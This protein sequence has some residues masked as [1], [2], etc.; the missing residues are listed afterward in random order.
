MGS[1][2]ARK[3]I[4]LISH[5]AEP[6]S[7]MRVGILG[8]AFKENVRDIRNSRVP[9]IVRELKHFGVDA[10]V[11]DPLADRGQA[12]DE[13]GITLV[14]QSSLCNLHALVLAVPHHELIAD[15]TALFGMLGPGAAFVDV[16]SVI[17]PST[18]P[19]GIR[20]WSL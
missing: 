13:Y 15:P 18:V 16:K 14:T 8:L 12:R 17:D 10:M 3:L 20:Y 7:G 9:D 2:I 19:A 5:I 4:H 6:F 1:F 11:C